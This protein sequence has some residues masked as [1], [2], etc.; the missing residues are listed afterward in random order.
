MLRK[1]CVAACKPL[2]TWRREW[3]SNPRYGFPYTRFPS[4]R[5]QPLGHLSRGFS[6]LARLP[7]GGNTLMRFTS[8]L[9]EKLYLENVSTNTLRWYRHGLKWLPCENP[10]ESQLKE[11]VVRMRSHEGA[12]TQANWL[13]CCNP[14]HQLLSEIIRFSAD[15]LYT[16]GLLQPRV[17]GFRL[18]QGW[19][20]RGR[21]CGSPILRTNWA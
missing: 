9:R 4:V 1:C 18:L 11:M 5:L 8:F 17:L 2:K 6:E 19:G 13:Q 21:H 7:L 3:D 20:C 16:L 10:D 14:R 15:R 12:G